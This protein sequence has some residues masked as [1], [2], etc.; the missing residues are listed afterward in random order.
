M[1]DMKV[2][3]DRLRS[4]IERAEQ[5]HS[6]KAD[7]AQQEKDLFA[8]AKSE[9]F[10]VAVMKKVIARRKRNADDLAEEDAVMDLYCQHLGM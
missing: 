8:E 3:P 9:G 7:L 5:L 1:T 4:F 10:D 2:T 6:E